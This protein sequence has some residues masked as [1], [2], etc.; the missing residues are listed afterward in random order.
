M[1]DSGDPE[2]TSGSSLEIPGAVSRA[3]PVDSERLG[4]I[5]EHSGLRRV[6]LLAWR[7]LDDPE[8]GGS[9]LHAHEIAARWASAGCEVVLRTSAVAGRS[10]TIERAGYRSVRRSGRYGVFL[11]GPFELASGRFGRLDG[12]VEIWNGMPFLSPLWWKGARCVFVHHVHAEMWHMTL[13]PRLARLGNAV[14]S[15]LAPPLYRSSRIV[16]LSD[17]SKREICAL[18]GISKHRVSVV[19]PGL[20]RRFSPGGRRSPRPL[21]VAVGRLVPVKRFDRLVSSLARLQSDAPGLEAVIVG[22]GYERA[23]LEALVDHA[24]LSGVVRLPGHLGFDELLE[25]YRRAWVVVSTSAREG[26]GMTLSEAGACGT[27][28]VAT[29]IAG[30]ADA[31]EDGVSGFLARDEREFDERLRQ[32]LSDSMLRRR[33][34]LG[35]ARRASSL[36]WEATALGTMEVLASERARMASSRRS[37]ARR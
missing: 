34:G 16:T 14:E 13:P 20:D 33:L 24:G 6:A 9:E 12:L 8:A 27:P 19:P 30:H 17:S 10:T 3:V 25:L 4:V 5:V 7:D 15:R 23:R 21:V 29:S 37:A 28:S 18:P 31:V 11:S 32:V 26:W 1:A 35:A 22:E 2:A 36:T